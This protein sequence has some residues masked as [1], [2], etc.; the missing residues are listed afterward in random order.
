MNKIEDIVQSVDNFPSFAYKNNSLFI[1]NV[2]LETVAKVH[3]TPA[4]VYS[5]NCC[6]NAFN[7][8]KQAFADADNLVCYAVKANSNLS[9]LSLFN[10]LGAGFDV[11]S[12]GE[13]RRV[14]KAG[15]AAEKTVFSGVAKT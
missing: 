1:E 7:A 3:G 2:E 12:E 4:Y 5:R 10:K 15:G 13:L 9:I 11:V 6:E 14:L 8:V